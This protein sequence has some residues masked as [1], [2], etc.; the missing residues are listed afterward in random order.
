MDSA[1]FKKTK[2]LDLSLISSQRHGQCCVWPFLWFVLMK[3]EGGSDR[4][5][6]I[7][8][9]IWS[10]FDLSSWIL[11]SFVVPKVSN[12]LNNHTDAS[13]IVVV[14]YERIFLCRGLTASFSVLVK[15]TAHCFL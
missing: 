8:K 7:G 9:R 12:L 13:C 3:T 4:K 11:S 2:F 14:I 1:R 10:G 6:G 5:S 15:R